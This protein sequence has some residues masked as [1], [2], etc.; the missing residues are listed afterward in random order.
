MADK[1]S[2]IKINEVIGVDEKT[3]RKLFD[4]VI[5]E[6]AD[7]DTTSE[8]VETLCHGHDPETFLLGIFVENVIAENEKLHLKSVKR[9]KQQTPSM[10]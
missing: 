2:I 3:S 9:I 4:S 6:F 7:R 5:K 1:N 8:A 10:N